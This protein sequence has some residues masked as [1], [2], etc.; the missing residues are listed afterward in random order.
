MNKIKRRSLLGITLVEMLLV[1]TI[2]SAA[3]YASV[4]YMQSR[5]QA[6]S[7]DRAA[8]QMQQILNAGLAY[9]VTNQAWPTSIGQL[10]TGG[11]LPAGTITGP[12][13][14]GYSLSTNSA[15]SLLTVNMKFPTAMSNHAAVAKILAGRLPM[16]SANTN[17]QPPC[18]SCI[19]PTAGGSDSN[20]SASVGIP[21]QNLNNATAVNFTGVYHNAGCVPVPKCPK[22]PNGTA[23]V[24]TI[25][26]SPASVSGMNDNV[27]AAYPISSFTAYATGPTSYTT[28]SAGSGPPPCASTDVMNPS[29]TCDLNTSGD[30]AAPTGTY[31][32]VCLQV[33]TQK[34]SVV[35][36]A[37]TGQYATV[38]AIT[39]CS[40]P[41]ENSGSSMGVWR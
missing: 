24:P 40:I 28:G 20:I 16:A 26:V 18:P 29:T 10:Q 3:I 41:T 12:W 13:G 5:T 23:M 9:Y 39:R 38:L 37:S 6:L 34:G 7:I 32:R 35:W 33:H 1:L 4:G 30:R 25:V 17:V 21:G 22:M 15:G 36:N 11:Y 2:A 14:Y 8:G 31:W 27:N 19:P